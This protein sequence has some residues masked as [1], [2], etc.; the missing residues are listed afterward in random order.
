MTADLIPIDL[1][2]FYAG[3][4]IIGLAL[5]GAMWVAARLERRP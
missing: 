5:A 1:A 3:T 4:A 2:T